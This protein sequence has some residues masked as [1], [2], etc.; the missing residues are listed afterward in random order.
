ME[1]WRE[2]LT[3]PLRERQTDLLVEDTADEGQFGVYRRTREILDPT[4]TSTKFRG[5]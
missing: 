4:I 5:K 1:W 3:D 2:S